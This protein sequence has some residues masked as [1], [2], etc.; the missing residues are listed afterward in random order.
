MK[1]ISVVFGTRPEAIKLAPV[2]IELKKHSEFEVN[3]CVT[4]QHREMLDQVLDTF[5]IKPDFDFNLMKQNQTLS[6]LTSEAIVKL[7]EYFKHY[8]PDLVFVQGDTTTVFAASIS[9]FYNKIKIAHVEAGLRTFD[10]SA[11]FPEEINRVLTSHIADIHFAPTETAKDNLIKEGISEEKIFVTGNTV[12]DALF[13]VKDIVRKKPPEVIGVKKEIFDSAQPI[14]LITG[15]RRENLGQGFENICAAIAELAIEFKDH[16]FIYPV[17]LNPNVRN[18]VNKILGHKKNI[19]VIEPL[20]YLP[21]VYLMSKA[22]IILTDSGGIQEEAP[23]LGKPVLVM[24][25]ITERPEAVKVGCVE[26]VGT[27][28]NKIIDKVKMLLTND[29]HYKRTQM[30]LNPYGDGLASK[31]IVDAIR[32]LKD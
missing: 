5:D 2:I 32:N 28:K 15:H 9:A 24:R 20:S 13:Y 11:P 1:K 22:K 16:Y 7:D 31:Y 26:L 23:T 18:P 14:V 10:K 17:H 4:A 27:N 12:I 19:L 3:L 8:K 29:K 6:D 21:F 30:V 25:D